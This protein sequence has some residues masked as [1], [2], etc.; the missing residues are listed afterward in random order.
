MSSW[1]GG[2]RQRCNVFDSIRQEGTLT[3]A[4]NILRNGYGRRPCLRGLPP[5]PQAISVAEA[6][7]YNPIYVAAW[8]DPKGDRVYNHSRDTQGEQRDPGDWN[9]GIS[10]EGGG[11]NH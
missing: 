10:M 7:G 11:V 2:W 8:R 5:P 9:L 6:C 1:R 3:S 4:Q